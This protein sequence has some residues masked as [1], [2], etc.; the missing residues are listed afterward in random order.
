MLQDSVDEP[1]NYEIYG[2]GENEKPTE[3]RFNASGLQKIAPGP[4]DKGNP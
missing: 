1:I 3:P 2:L 4:E